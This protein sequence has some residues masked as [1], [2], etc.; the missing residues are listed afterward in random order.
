MPR[1]SASSV[2]EHR[3]QIQQRIFDAFA[4][5]MAEQSFDAITMARLAA[6]AGLGRTAI[7]HHFPSKEAVV[8]AFASQET[9][10]Y[11][12]GLTEVLADVDDP[13][14]RLR[15]YIRHQV[16]AGEKFHM[17]LGRQ[18]YGALSQET[19]GAIRDHVAAIEAVLREILAR[20]VAAGRFTVDDEAATMSLIHACLAPRDLPADLVERFVVRALGATP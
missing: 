12:T 16:D 1:I 10:R 6:E 8:V 19:M 14:E 7:Y 17:G 3:E 18:L 2:G 13:V 11:I 5:L 15:L 9:S 20:G 4:T